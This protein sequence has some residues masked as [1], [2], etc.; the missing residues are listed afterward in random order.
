MNRGFPS[1]FAPDSDEEF[2]SDGEGAKEEQSK[3]TLL[4]L[5][6]SAYLQDYHLTHVPK[7]LLA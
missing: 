7:P 5:E 6:V 3:P 2:S 1:L 4:P